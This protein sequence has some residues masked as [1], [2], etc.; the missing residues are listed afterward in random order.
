MTIKASCP[1]CAG[2]F[3]FDDTQVGQASSCPHCQS[4]I[5]LTVPAPPPAPAASPVLVRPAPAV[6]AV[7]GVR[8]AV[9]TRPEF[10]KRIRAESSY[11]TARQL[12]AVLFGLLGGFG[13]LVI[14]ASA[15]GLGAGSSGSLGGGSFA[16]GL[17]AGSVIVV[18]ALAGYQS[19]V[20]VFDISDTLIDGRGT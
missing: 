7:P 6:A 5:T 13:V 14:G 9:E 3:S 15:L 17:A 4:Q 16:I 10:L 8:K 2:H 19:A 18:L 1:S 20:V 12:A 11:E